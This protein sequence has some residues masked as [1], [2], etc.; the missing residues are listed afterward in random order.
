MGTK[1]NSR[2]VCYAEDAGVIQSNAFPGATLLL[3]TKA[4]TVMITL[5]VILEI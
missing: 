1:Q 4:A 3:R 5:L 2:D